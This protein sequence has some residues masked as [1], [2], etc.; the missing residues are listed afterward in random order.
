MRTDAGTNR[1][2]SIHPKIQVLVNELHMEA[3]S[4]RSSFLV[5]YTGSHIY[6]SSKMTYDKY[7]KRFKN[8]IKELGINQEYRAYDGRK[9]QNVKNY[10]C[11]PSR[12]KSV[13]PVPVIASGIV[14]F[15]IFNVFYGCKQ[16]RNNISTSSY[17]LIYLAAT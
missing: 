17:F 16:H 4:R 7:Q 13:I 8:T 3:A 6:C 11:R 9:Q 1:T 5:Y 12:P 15:S 2:I 10:L 14:I